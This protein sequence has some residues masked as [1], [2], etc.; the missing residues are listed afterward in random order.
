MEIKLKCY[1]KFGKWE[2]TTLQAINEPLKVKPTFVKIN[3]ATNFVY[4]ENGNLNEK[5]TF[6]DTFI[7]DKKFMFVGKLKVKIE[8]MLNGVIVANYECEDLILKQD[9]GIRA[10]PEIEDLKA[11]I[12]N[13]NK[14]ID[15]LSKEI[16]TLHKLV[17]ADCLIEGGK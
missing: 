11:Q 12:K 6:K 1:Q 8:I 5:T 17:Y 7:I 2:T 13:Q 3:G 14:I 15:N 4:I 10:I 9:N 16:E